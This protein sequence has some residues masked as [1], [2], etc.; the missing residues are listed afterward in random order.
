MGLPAADSRAGAR[1]SE[2]TVA[3]DCM[4]GQ[5]HSFKCTLAPPAPVEQVRDPLKLG[6]R[7][8]AHSQ[9]HSTLQVSPQTMDGKGSKAQRLLLAPTS[10][11]MTAR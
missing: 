11:D 10:R 5:K 8:P 3:A 6:L 9:A 4:A 7:T 2:G 1:L